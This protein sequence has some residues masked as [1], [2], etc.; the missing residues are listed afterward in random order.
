VLDFVDKSFDFAKIEKYR[1]SIQIDL[2]GFSFCIYDLAQNKHVVLRN[3]SYGKNITGYADLSNAT[4]NIMANDE[5]LKRKYSAC[6]CVYISPKNTLIPEKLFSESRLRSYLEFMQPLDELD[7][8][9][10]DFISTL[11]S[12]CV[13]TMPSPVIAEVVRHLGAVSFLNQACKSVH[14][15]LTRKENNLT[16]SFH[17]DFADVTLF[18]NGRLQFHNTFEISGNKDALYYLS[19]VIH[20]FGVAKDTPVH[21]SGDMNAGDIAELKHYLPSVKV[22]NNRRMSL[23]VGYERSYRYYRLLSLHE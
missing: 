16:V 20:Q 7:E 14:E 8:I 15:S 22:D 1:L 5:F 4:A 21:V 9:R 18:Y 11:G 13:F 10:Y 3:I 17:T 23:L 6:N 19:A 12:Y 2:N